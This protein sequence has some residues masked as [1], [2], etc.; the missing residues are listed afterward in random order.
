MYS[1]AG[2]E[3]CASSAVLS[4]GDPVALEMEDY[5]SLKQSDF[6]CGMVNGKFDPTFFWVD[7]KIEARFPLHK[8]LP[9]SAYSGTNH[10]ATSERS[11][12]GVTRQL[13]DLR[14]QLPVEQVCAAVILN[15]GE[16]LHKTSIAE[17]MLHYR[18]KRTHA[19][20][21]A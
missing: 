3:M 19:E 11:F 8:E 21:D 12:S 16:Q 6:V 2:A 4:P 9:K 1:M 7:A 17:V 18:S 14:S 20:M 10:E 15:A 13:G 5:K